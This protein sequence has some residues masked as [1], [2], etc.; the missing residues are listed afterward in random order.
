[1]KNGNENLET[2]YSE[3]VAKGGGLFRGVQEGYGSV[4]S[5][6]LFDDASHPHRS[7]LA[8]SATELT[9]DRVRERLQTQQFTYSRANGSRSAARA[10]RLLHVE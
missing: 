4:P 7:T 5:L 2:I 6:V 8:V 9:V 1:M 10:R 3:I